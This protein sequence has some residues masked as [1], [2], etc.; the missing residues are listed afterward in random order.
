[1]GTEHIL[2]PIHVLRTYIN[3]A[4][5]ILFTEDMDVKNYDHLG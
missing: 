1:M 2:L 3:D 5:Q 4:A